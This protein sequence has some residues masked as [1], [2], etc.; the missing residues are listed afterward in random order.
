M[1][2]IL[3]ETY[4]NPKIELTQ[5]EYNHLVDL[6]KMKAK[7]I[8]ERA[9][10]FYEKEGVA[11]IC[12]EGRINK[13]EFGESTIQHY[14]FECNP[15]EYDVSPSGEFEPSLFKIPMEQ[16][17]R[18][19]QKVGRYVEDVFTANFGERLCHLNEILKIK[20]KAERDLQRFIICTIV[21]WLVA[22]IM[23]IIVIFR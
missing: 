20:A 4:V 19:A 23:L 13:K 21:G 11:K 8:E 6:A 22:L 1:E 12:F 16:R 18:I 14:K 9:R 17:K 2:K 3:K 7:K 10:E 15:R 5:D